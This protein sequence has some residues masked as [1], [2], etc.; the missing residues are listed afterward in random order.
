MK[1][2]EQRDEGTKR[3]VKEE[4]KITD[5]NAFTVSNIRTTK[6]ARFSSTYNILSF[7]EVHIADIDL[8]PNDQGE[9]PFKYREEAEQQT[10]KEDKTNTT[11]HTTKMI[12]LEWVTADESENKAA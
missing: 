1:V 7:T 11:T 5:E 2:D 12:R 8:K 4:L 10:A 3:A 9:L 6:E